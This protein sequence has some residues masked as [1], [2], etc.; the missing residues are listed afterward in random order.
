MI[1]NQMQTY[2]MSEMLK[3][4]YG[5]DEGGQKIAAFQSG[6]ETC[7]DVVAKELAGLLDHVES[8]EELST[9]KE[10]LDFLRANLFSQPEVEHEETPEATDNVQ[11]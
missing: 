5:D 10:V 8:M 4:V 2:V 6:Y 9:P 11:E 3:S 7:S 1:L